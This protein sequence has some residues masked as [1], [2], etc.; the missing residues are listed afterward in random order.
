MGD[1]LDY[2]FKVWKHLIF[3]IWKQNESPSNVQS[4]CYPCWVLEVGQALEAR[5]QSKAGAILWKRKHG[6]ASL[7]CFGPSR[8]PAL[9]SSLQSSSP[10]PPSATPIKRKS[11][12]Y[13]PRQERRRKAAE[14]ASSCVNSVS[15]SDKDTV[16]NNLQNKVSKSSENLKEVLPQHLDD[17]RLKSLLTIPHLHLYV[18]SVTNV[19]IQTAL[20]RA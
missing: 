12:S 10:P 13:L 15:E 18:L 8:P 6:N 17:S 20:I 2:I 9:P 3:R 4:W 5:K 1:F 16:E 7:S 19:T 14:K 11:P